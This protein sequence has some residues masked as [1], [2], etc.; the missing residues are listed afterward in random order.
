LEAG[1]GPAA[2]VQAV[3]RSRG[4][5][6]ATGIGRR[7]PPL[8]GPTIRRVGYGREKYG[9]G[10]RMNPRDPRLRQVPDPRRSFVS[11]RSGR[12]EPRTIVGR[13]RR[14]R[15]RGWPGPGARSPRTAA[16]HARKHA[17]IRSLATDRVAEAAR[18]GPLAVPV[19]ELLAEGGERRRVAVRS[20][21]GSGSR[22]LGRSWPVVGET[23]APTRSV[24]ARRFDE[25]DRR[26]RDVRMSGWSTSR[27]A[28][29]GWRARFRTARFR[30]ASLASALWAFRVV[31]QP[32]L[33]SGAGRFIG[34]AGNRP[35]SE[36][37]EVRR[38]FR[39]TS[40]VDPDRRG[41]QRVRS[42]DDRPVAQD[43]RVAPHLSPGP[44]GRAAIGS[45]V[46][47]KRVRRENLT[48]ARWPLSRGPRPAVAA[49]APSRRLRH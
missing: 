35:N 31:G 23:V 3:G 2:A 33:R 1:P 7:K 11:I 32:G 34:R 39:S 40:P 30:I 22:E 6:R 41:R 26:P 24:G 18:S 25:G 43:P 12:S 9:G 16:C 44:A 38:R 45:N 42:P 14:S 36:E 29:H 13:G 10:P 5:C 8:A 20:R 21:D 27:D 28:R 4:R 48:T 37:D 15:A 49:A 47:L 19:G 17:R 46:L